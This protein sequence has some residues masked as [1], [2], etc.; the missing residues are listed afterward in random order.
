MEELKDLRNKFLK[1]E[2]PQTCFW[3]YS[4]RI[5]TRLQ[6]ISEKN[7]KNLGGRSITR[8]K[9]FINVSGALAVSVAFQEV[10]EEICGVPR[11]SKE[12]HGR[13]T[14]FQEI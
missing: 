1:N 5:C 9:N 11:D 4:L 6:G 8:I 12:F 13:S 2:E 7:Q 14:S 10:S 3:S